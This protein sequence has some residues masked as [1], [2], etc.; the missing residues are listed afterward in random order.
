M[1]R[2]THILE[3]TVGGTARHLLDVGCG[4]AGEGFQVEALLSARPEE[5]FAEGARR[6]AAAGVA[7]TWVPMVRE[8]SPRDDARAARLLAAHLRHSRPDLVHT[9]SS[10]AGALGRLAAT[11]ARVPVVVHSPHAFAF[12]MRVGTARRGLYLAI[13]RALA[14][15]THC[16]VAVSAAEAAL[17]CSRA[18]YPK[19]RVAIIENGV[20]PEG[21]APPEEG[22]ALRRELG[23]A[24]AAP[25]VLFAGRLV[26]QKAPEVLVAAAVAVLDRHPNAVFLLAGEGPLRPRLEA[27]I[28]RA[29]RTANIRLLGH[30]SDMARLYATAQ[31]FVLPAR[32][33]GLPYALLD[34]LRAGLPVVASEI[35]ALREV[36]VHADAGLLVPPDDPPALAA[37]MARLLDD[38]AGAARLGAAG[39]A[40]VREHY[41]VQR[42]VRQLAALYR[43]LAAGGRAPGGNETAPGVV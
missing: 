10:K 43:R 22:A 33:E 36:V 15:R 27:E 37:A 34:A 20:D 21:A 38:P 28:A 26:E 7:V 39:R 12:Q 35:P 41:T 4:L 1:L 17:A 5:S 3:A 25:V 6:L 29:G 8:L 13:E 24:P 30:R 40:C 19:E 16:L 9:H 14:R 42:Q 11:L 32:W 31:L 2:V 23:I 18:G